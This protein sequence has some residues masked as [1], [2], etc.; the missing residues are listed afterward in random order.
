M[1]MIDDVQCNGLT[2]TTRFLGDSA[3]WCWEIHE[4]ASGRFLDSSWS[5]EWMAYGSP[6]EAQTAGLARL[7]DLASRRR[8]RVA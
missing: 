3:L 7:G 8:P 1:A 2:L 4:T 5:S 6:S